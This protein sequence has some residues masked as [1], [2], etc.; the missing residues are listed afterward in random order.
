M[1]QNSP[2]PYIFY[3]IANKVGFFFKQI[4][5]FEMKYAN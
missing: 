3:A 2:E 1:D 5:S 4:E